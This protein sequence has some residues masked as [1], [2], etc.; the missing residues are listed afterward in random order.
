MKLRLP[1][2]GYSRGYEVIEVDSDTLEGAMELLED[3][4]YTVIDTVVI[5]DDR[6]R[7]PED[8]SED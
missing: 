2:S 3:Y 1:F 8:A 5:R 6:E 7:A 4:Q